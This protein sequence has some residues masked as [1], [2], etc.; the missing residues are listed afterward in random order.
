MPNVSNAHS[1][2]EMID[3]VAAMPL[4]AMRMLWIT[5]WPPCERT[6]LSSSARASTP[7]SAFAIFFFVTTSC[8]L[9]VRVSSAMVAQIV[10]DQVDLIRLDVRGGPSLRFL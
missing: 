9:R 2:I 5:R 10:S 8:I 1:R 4:F 7:P 3:L 6:Y